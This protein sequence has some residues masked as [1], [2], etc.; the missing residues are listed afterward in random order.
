ME[1]F[2]WALATIMLIGSK[3][4]TFAETFFVC[5]TLFATVGVFATIIANIQIILEDIA[6]KSKGYRKD[7]EVL[8]QLFESNKNISKNT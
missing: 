8:N 3:G 1:S 6:K 2:Y 7:L 4:N 5:V